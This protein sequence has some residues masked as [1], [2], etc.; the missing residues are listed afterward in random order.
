MRGGGIEAVSDTKGDGIMKN[1]NEE[2]IEL[3]DDLTMLASQIREAGQGEGALPHPW[4]ID[5]WLTRYRCLYR[6]GDDAAIIEKSQ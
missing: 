3:A 4:H 6:C 1:D 2:V 5:D